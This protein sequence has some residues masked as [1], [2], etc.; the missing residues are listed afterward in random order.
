MLDFSVEDVEQ[1]IQQ[2]IRLLFCETVKVIRTDL[3]QGAFITL[4]KEQRKGVDH[5]NYTMVRG[6]LAE[7]FL[8]VSII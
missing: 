8:I 3:S 1:V 6:Y 2:L 7:T 4:L 5:D